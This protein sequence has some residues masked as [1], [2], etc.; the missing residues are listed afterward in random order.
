MKTTHMLIGLMAAGSIVMAGSVTIPNTFV[1]GQT[2]KASEVNA[3]FS[4]VKSAVNGNDNDITTNASDIQSNASA[5]ATKQEKVVSNCAVGSYIQKI[6][7]DG[8]VVCAEDK[9]SGAQMWVRDHEGN[10][11]PTVKI[12]SQVWMADNMYVTTYP[13][14]NPI[15][16]VSTWTDGTKDAFAYPIKKSSNYEG[17]DDT[18]VA[19][20]GDI[21]IKR[22][23][24]FYQWEAAVHGDTDGTAQGICPSGWHIPTSDE[25]DTLQAAL[26]ST[27]YLDNDYNNGKN[28]K[29]GEQLR[30][31]G[32]SGF[33][34]LMTGRL[35]DDGINYIHRGMRTHFWTA[36]EDTGNAGH[37]LIRSLYN[38]V[39]GM[40]RTH[41]SQQRGVSVRCL[42]D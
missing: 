14:G 8:T 1:A 33:G 31:G 12:G 42:K 39:P 5:I 15:E 19:K 17:N 40:A 6:N 38:G 13:N 18:P 3:N 22:Y 9:D 7:A 20:K 37:A 4:A 35:L 10:I 27:T 21:D 41:T 34:A 29:V 23:G 11:H 2:A 26:G 36:D 24:L 28:E 16:D 30:L 32:K 25:W